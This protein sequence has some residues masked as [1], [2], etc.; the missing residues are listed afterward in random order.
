MSLDEMLAPIDKLAKI[1]KSLDSFGFGYSNTHIDV[2]LLVRVSR[3]ATCSHYASIRD[4]SPGLG[5]RWKV[6]TRSAILDNYI[7]FFFLTSPRPNT[8]VV[9]ACKPFPFSNYTYFSTLFSKCF[10][11]IHYCTC[12]LSGSRQYLALDGIHHP[13]RAA[14]PGNSTPWWSKK[15]RAN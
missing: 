9:S 7:S 3:R 4:K 13:L 11:Y 1:L 15:S 6:W 10:A 8:K 14:F 2:R 12:S 5:M